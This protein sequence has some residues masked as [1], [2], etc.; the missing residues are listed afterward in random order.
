MK[1]SG[2][3]R[4][5]FPAPYD[6]HSR[7]RRGLLVHIVGP[8]GTGKSTLTQRLVE[9]LTPELEVHHYYWRPGLLPM[10]GRVVGKPYVGLVTDPHG[11]APHG[12][13]KAILRLSYYLVDFIVGYWVVYRPIL[14]RGGLVL[15]ERGWQD[16]VVDSRR[17]LMPNRRPARIFS[18]LVPRPDVIVILKA[19]AE[20][21]LDRKD[22]I[23]A[24]EIDRQIR[25]W[26]NTAVARREVIELD[27]RMAPE[28]LAAAV[29][30]RLALHP[31]KPYS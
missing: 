15:V 1:V 13:V 25:E 27:A 26:R 24:E 5:K 18:V 30:D 9:T 28:E 8:D 22:E 16:L 12:R 21:V 10:P 31:Q 20:T 23:T 29:I 4:K 7:R 2:V 6:A 19:P 11:H 17:Y 14:R 3:R